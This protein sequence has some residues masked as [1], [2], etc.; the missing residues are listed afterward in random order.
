MT[1]QQPK[2]ITVEG[3][4]GAGKSTNVGIIKACLDDAGIAYLHTR[5]P[6]GTPLAE[7]I[8]ALLLTKREE[9]VA[10]D[11]ELLMAFAARAQHIAQVIRPALARGQWVLCDRFTDATFAYQGSGRGIPNDKIAQ[12]ETMVQQGLQPDLTLLFDLPVEIGMERAR[13]RGAL[14]R[15]ESEQ[16]AFFE[17]V[18]RGYLERAR[19]HPQRF[20]ILDASQGLESVAQQ[21]RQLM[22]QLLGC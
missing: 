22:T 13:Q 15:F 17:R 4:E 1:E 6:G 10:A 16:I 11:T 5:E 2:F 20:H 21:V 7:E 14:D 19:Q 8:R 3:G 9:P 12:L 18:R